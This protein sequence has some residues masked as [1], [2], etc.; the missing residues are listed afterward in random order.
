ME[1]LDANTLVDPRSGKEI[2]LDAGTFGD[3]LAYIG[4]VKSFKGDYVF[5]REVLDRTEGKVKEAPGEGAD[6]LA[7]IREA[8]RLREERL[9]ERE[10]GQN[11]AGK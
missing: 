8:A 10:R 5:Y 9:R 2:H 6:V 11:K 1:L 7:A 4:M 3:L